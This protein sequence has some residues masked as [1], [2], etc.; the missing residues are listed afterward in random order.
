MEYLEKLNGLIVRRKALKPPGNFTEKKM[1]TARQDFHVTAP[2]ME[3]RERERQ[4]AIEER[5]EV[6]RNKINEFPGGT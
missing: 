3:L 1:I 5:A 6:S 2:G 4:R